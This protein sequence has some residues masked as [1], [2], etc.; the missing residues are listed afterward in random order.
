[1]FFTPLE[2]WIEQ[3]AIKTQ[4]LVN[5]EFDRVGT[6]QPGSALDQLGLRDG[7]EIVRDY[8][9]HGEAGVAFEHLLYMVKELDLVLPADT[10]ALIE[11]EGDKL[12]LHAQHLSADETR[13]RQLTS[14]CT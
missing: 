14:R 11:Q 13:G 6:P 3:A 4:E 10:Y 1:M 12:G 8:L 2:S 7:L 5:Q 9:Q